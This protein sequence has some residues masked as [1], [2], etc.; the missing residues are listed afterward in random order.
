MNI[1]IKYEYAKFLILM[2]KSSC[3]YYHHSLSPHSLPPSGCQLFS[4]GNICQLLMKKLYS[5]SGSESLSHPHHLSA[6]LYLLIKALIT[7]YLTVQDFSAF[8]YYIIRPDVLGSFSSYKLLP[9]W[10]AQMECNGLSDG[11][12]LNGSSSCPD[13]ESSSDGTR[14]TTNNGIDEDGNERNTNDSTSSSRGW[15]ALKLLLDIEKST[16]RPLQGVP[17]ILLSPAQG[18]TIITLFLMIVLY[19][20]TEGL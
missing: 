19:V 16:I 15:K 10:I 18:T 2:S 12:S 9:P 6:P 3:H 13:H 5:L 8:L 17:Y 4:E 11:Y 1:C 20:H 14:N 7:N